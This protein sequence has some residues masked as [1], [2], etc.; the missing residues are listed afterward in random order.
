MRYRLGKTFTLDISVQP[1]GDAPAP[2]VKLDVEEVI[3][4]ARGSTLRLE[5]PTTTPETHNRLLELRAYLV[6]HDQQP[7]VDVDGYL[8]S[9]LPYALVDVSG[10][11]H[12]EGG[13]VS[14][15]LPSVDRMVPY[16]GQLVHGY[17]D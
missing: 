2:G 12:S 5:L 14:I 16:F 9:D 17:A 7:P 1:G 3:L 13:P 15:T 11:A 8:A 4:E 10:F 6:P